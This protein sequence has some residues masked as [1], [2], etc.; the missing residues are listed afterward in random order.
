MCAEVGYRVRVADTRHHVLALR[1]EQV[2]AHHG[3]LARGRVARERDARAGVESHV[4]EDHRHDIDGGAK[5]IGDA[6]RAAII[7]GAFA[8]P[9]FEDSLGSQFKLLVHILRE[10]LA[11]VFFVFHLENTDQ[12]FPIFG[13]HF[14]VELVALLFLVFPHGMFEHLV[15]QAEDGGAEHFDQA[16]VRVPGK[17]GIVRQPGEAFHH[18]IVQADVQDGVHHA[19]H[20][21]FCAR[22]ARDE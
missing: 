8:H 9:G 19:R 7:H 14:R 18:F 5:I 3:L 6:G 20:G 21:E 15:I 16:A 4:A 12:G 2:L 13:G 1:V 17:A 11:N 10:I 22:T